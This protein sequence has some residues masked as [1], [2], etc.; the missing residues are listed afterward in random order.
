MKSVQSQ[1]AWC[2]RAQ[3]TMTTIMVSLIVL[4]FAFVFWPANRRLA[5]VAEEMISKS[6]Q[7][8]ANQSRAADLPKLA[9]QVAAL[10]FKL[11]RFNKK[12]PKTAE[13]DEFLRELTTAAQQLSIRKLVHQPGTVKRQD[14]FGEIPITMSFEG[15]STDVYRFIREL[16]GMSR[17]T[18]VKSLTVHCKDSKLGLVDVNLAMNIYFSEQ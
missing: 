7:L 18:R 16:E 17:L 15:A 9:L 12:L 2:A 11:E 5:A 1:I 6:R 8:E 4:F 13:F 14:L 3:W 10:R